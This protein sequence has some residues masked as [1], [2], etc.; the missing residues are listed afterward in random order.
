MPQACCTRLEIIQDS[1]A[2]P[3]VTLVRTLHD[4]T[5]RPAGVETM[6]WDGSADDGSPVPP[7]VYLARVQAQTTLSGPINYASTIVTVTA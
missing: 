6:A 2:Q 4:W 3:G 5:Q 1:D 7:G